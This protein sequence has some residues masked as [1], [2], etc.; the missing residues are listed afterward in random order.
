MVPETR[1]FVFTRFK[2]DIINWTCQMIILD[3][4][5]IV[6]FQPVCN[7]FDIKYNRLI[8]MPMWLY[9]VQIDSFL[10]GL[11]EHAKYILSQQHLSQ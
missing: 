6:P 5:F 3:N 11:V 8:L 7:Q 4:E 2:G 1:R 10:N 9:L